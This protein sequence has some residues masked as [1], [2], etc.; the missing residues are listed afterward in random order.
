M[1]PSRLFIERPVATTL[2]MLALFFAGLLGLRALPLSA[3]PEVDYPT[4][5]VSTLYPGAGPELM[6]AAVTAPLE[7]RLGQMPGLAQMS[8]TSSA[9]ASLITLRF[10]LSLPLDIAAQQVQAALS[11]ATTLL[12]ADLPAP[13]VYSKINPADAAVLTLAVTSPTLPLPRVHDLV[14]SRLAPKIA[15]LGGVGLVSIAGGRRPAV[16]VQADPGLLARLQLSL[17]DLRI[18]IVGANVNLAKG[19]FDG[20]ERASTIDANDQLKTAAE[21]ARLPVVVRDG[22]AVR[23][24]ELARVT[25]DTENQRQA[26]WADRAEDPVVDDAVVDAVQRAAAE[27]TRRVRGRR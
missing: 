10:A 11:A 4:I 9:G 6:A 1:N 3:L 17:E 23:L 12:P 24:G 14:E 7:R 26:A 16:R 19:G 5:Q 25:D 15:Q 21:Y 27:L 22:V 20:P 8:S 18:A 2:L 13:P